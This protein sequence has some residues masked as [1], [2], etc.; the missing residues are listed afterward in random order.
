MH[1][2]GVQPFQGIATPEALEGL[3]FHTIQRHDLPRHVQRNTR[4][5]L[6]IKNSSVLKYKHNVADIL[7]FKYDVNQMS[8]DN[9]IK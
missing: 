6:K 3:Q 7:H 2:V 8:C 5:I 9:N 4:R 1:Q